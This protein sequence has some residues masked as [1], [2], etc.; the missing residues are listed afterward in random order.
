VEV[1]EEEGRVR[2]NKERLIAQARAQVREIGPQEL[3][4]QLARG[5]RP[6]VVDVREQDEY[7]QGYI[8]GAIHIPRGFLELRIEDVTADRDRPIVLYCAGGVR[9]A[10]AAKSLREMG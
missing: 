4:E 8:A 9:S 1:Y 2:I 7:A 5:D 3:W 10:L 6:I